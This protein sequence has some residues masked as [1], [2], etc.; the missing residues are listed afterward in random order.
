MRKLRLHNV[1]EVTRFAMQSGLSEVKDAKHSVSGGASA[2]R[3][4]RG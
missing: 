1:A 3:A 4:A 2:S